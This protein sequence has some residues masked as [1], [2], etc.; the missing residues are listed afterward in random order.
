MGIFKRMNDIIT[1]NFNELIE[2]FEDPE[3][4]LKQAIREME[5]AIRDAMNGAARVIADE[6]LLLRQIEVHHKDAE[7]WRNQARE[8][9]QRGDDEAARHA[10]LRKRE[11]DKLSVALEDQQAMSAEIARKLRTQIEA[12][13]VRL[14]EAKRKLVTLSARQQVARTRKQFATRFGDSRFN[15]ESFQNFDRICERVEREEAE[16]YAELAGYPLDTTEEAPFF[17]L[18]VEAE[19]QALK[20][21]ETDHC[22]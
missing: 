3:T 6:K 18:E 9:I 11:H 8:A 15:Q 22:N 17:D 19:L 20:N 5:N 12:M 4:M 14:E 10:L 13:Q 1:A 21:E 7:I 2:K 16:A